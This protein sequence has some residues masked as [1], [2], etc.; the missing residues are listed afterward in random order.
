MIK[1]V[2]ISIVSTRISWKRPKKANGFVL[3]NLKANGCGNIGGIRMN[4]KVI[5]H[6]CWSTSKVKYPPLFSDRV[7]TP[8]RHN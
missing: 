1:N 6:D 5:V 7:Q 4:S 2:R 3:N 8:K